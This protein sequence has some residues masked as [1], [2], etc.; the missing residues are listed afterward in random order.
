VRELV[1][2][3]RPASGADGRILPVPSLILSDPRAVARV[4]LPLLAG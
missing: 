4:S 1:V 3:Y 2:A